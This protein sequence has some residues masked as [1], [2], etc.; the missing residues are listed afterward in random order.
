M[1]MKEEIKNFQTVQVDVTLSLDTSAYA[2]GDVLAEMQAV[3]LDVGYNTQVGLRGT[4]NYCEV[5]DKDDQG[6]ALDVVFMDEEGS[7]GAV[8]N[9]AVAIT[10]ANAIKVIGNVVV[11]TYADFINSQIARP[12]FYPI[13]FNTD[14][15][16]TIYVGA[17][18][19]GAG[20][21]TAAGIVLRMGFTLDNVVK[22]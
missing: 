19:R 6:E 16:G 10:D 12:E 21:Y 15:T 20:T 9:A 7:L 5:V 14:K 11:S 18:S 2:D 4:I 3:E 22:T 17:I 1:A 13:P 8:E